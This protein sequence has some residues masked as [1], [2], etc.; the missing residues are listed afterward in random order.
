MDRLWT[1]L[2]MLAQDE[3][4]RDAVQSLTNMVER[5]DLPDK[6]IDW[7]KQPDMNALAAINS[8]FTG[9]GLYLSAYEL[10]EINRWLW[11]DRTKFGGKS[12]AALSAYWAA[13]NAP[14]EPSRTFFEAAGALVIDGGVR[15]SIAQQ[16]TTFS[17]H[18]FGEL[19]G[20][21]QETLRTALRDGGV[22]DN[23]AKEFFAFSWSGSHCG[24]I[25]KAYA[26]WIHLNA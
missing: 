12:M 20:P 5:L 17:E 1:A 24:S 10:S 9:K 26:G 8:I 19:T 25:I 4:L 11:E 7:Q 21:E 15:H 23:K 22:A 6:P 16:E 2:G 18:G 3:Q 14:A 13:L